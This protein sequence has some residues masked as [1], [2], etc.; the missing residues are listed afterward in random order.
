MD[1]TSYK[2]Y[3]AYI[4]QGADILRAHHITSFTANHLRFFEKFSDDQAVWDSLTDEIDKL[5]VYF[6]AFVN[7]NI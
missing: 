3:I 5:T 2:D 1:H 7:C 6:L 4:V